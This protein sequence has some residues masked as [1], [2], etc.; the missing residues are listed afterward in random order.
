MPSAHGLSASELHQVCQPEDIPFETTATADKVDG[1][2]VGQDRAKEALRF[3]VGIQRQGY[4]IFAM[5]DAGVG[6]ETLLLRFLQE[7]AAKGQVPSDWCY[8]HDFNSP[9]H[10]RAM[11][12]PPGTGLSLQRD[13]MRAVAELQ[14]GIRS[15][16]DSQEHRTRRQ[17]IIRRFKDRQESAI[18]EAQERA[19]QQGVAVINTDSGM[20][21]APLEAGS[22]MN[23]DRFHD[24]PEERRAPLQAIMTRVGADVQEVLHHFHDWAHEHF[25]ALKAL[26]REMATIAATRVL[27]RVRAKHAA[28][29]TVVT[30][31]N[32]VEA[33]V[34]DRAADFLEEQSD[35]V[36]ALVRRAIKREHAD[37]APFVRYQV[38]VLVDRTGQQGAPVVWEENPTY[39]NLIGRIDHESQFGA[40]S[41][42]FTLIKAG[43]LHNAIDGYLVVDAVK[44]LQSPFAWE[45][46]K[47]VLRSGHIRL[48]SLS[49]SLGL[50]PTVTVEPEPIALGRIKVVLMGD[51]MVYSL[52]SS[53]D[54][55]F[56]EL[57]KTLVDFEDTLDWH[58]DSQRRYA[59]LIAMLVSSEGLRPFDRTAVA[60]VIEHAARLAGDSQKLS[61]HLRSIV[62]LLQEADYQTGERG[63]DVTS[64]DDVQR[65]IDAHDARSGRVR[66]RL[67]EAI[68]RQDILIATDG[69]AVGQVNGLSVVPLG[70]HLVGQ[71]MRI[72]ARTRLG[73]G[74]VIDIEREVEL[75]GPIHSK[76]VLIITSFLGARYATG[77]PLSLSASLVFE[78]SYG[79]VDGD[80]ASMAELCAL[81]S[82]LADAPLRQSL[83]ITGS[84]N[85]QGQSQSIGGVNDKIEGFFDICAERGLTGDQGVLIPRSNIKNLMLRKDVVDAVANNR[86]HVHAYADVDE[87]MALLTDQPMGVVGNDGDFTRGSVNA[88]IV[89]RLRTF[90]DNARAF[91][92]TLADVGQ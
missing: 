57:F 52:L 43:A 24:L 14:V 63:Q 48:E 41:T 49:Q 21:I 82:S 58:P 37:G 42:N 18:V 39:A 28:L 70:D 66:E 80:S 73:R 7:H 1:L 9:D 32:D 59:H 47:R 54:P 5:G 30:Y 35:G 71:P 87:A 38:N 62:D 40:L 67:R 50:T 88:R 2:V 36:D 56:P 29:P 13:M 4:N 11:E 3:G 45:A 46:L 23:P 90:A 91:P 76:G 69:T 77:A 53:S 26:D 34:I 25:E 75:G 86:F 72:T 8:V 78:Q 92:R 74:E 22:P 20:I 65:A 81:L 27:D 19:S 17:H 64:A 31:L 61:T 44:M 79:D 15:A 10:P 85:Q 89:T 16:F 55:D 6:K 51:R 83:A 84:V 12:L 33:D 68:R 60:R